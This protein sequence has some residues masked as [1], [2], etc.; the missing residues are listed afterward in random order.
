M[1][2]HPLQF[3]TVAGENIDLM[4]RDCRSAR[5]KVEN[6]AAVCCLA[7]RLYPGQGL[8][9][10]VKPLQERGRIPSRFHLTLGMSTLKP[11]ELRAGDPESFSVCE[12]VK[13]PK[14]WRNMKRF[15]DEVIE[16]KRS[17]RCTGYLQVMV[18]PEGEVKYAHSSDIY[19]HVTV[20]SSQLNK[21]VLIVFELFRVSL[22]ISK[23]F[24]LEVYD[25][26]D[27]SFGQF[28]TRNTSLKQSAHVHKHDNGYVEFQP[29][30]R[31]LLTK[32]PSNAV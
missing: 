19:G 1:E 12:R 28:D 6:P 24:D 20:P 22:E 2:D 25:Y 26:A 7:R 27:I 32:T 3:H 4:D 5:L 8:M 30:Y 9:L 11:E 23:T 31:G 17:N 21:G 16:G 29:K 10:K 18:T 14:R 15:E 13:K